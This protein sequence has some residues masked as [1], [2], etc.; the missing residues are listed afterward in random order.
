MKGTQV[1]EFICNSKSYRMKKKG[2]NAGM[3]IFLNKSSKN[4]RMFV[5]KMFLFS[6]LERQ[7]KNYK[8][9]GSN[10]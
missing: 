4:V 10:R 3:V 2:M 1:E 6:D 9:P 7:L 8:L 5:L